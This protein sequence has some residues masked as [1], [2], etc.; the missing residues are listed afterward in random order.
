M[1]TCADGHGAKAVVRSRKIDFVLLDLMM[2]RIDGLA[3]LR[4]LRQDEKSD[5]PVLMLSAVTK[6]GVKE[7]LVEAGANGV[8]VKPV[9]APELLKHIE[10]L[11][12]DRSLS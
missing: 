5:V 11:L 10:K 3:F 1:C 7:T 4:W 8:L 9:G 12:Q 6:A 2:P